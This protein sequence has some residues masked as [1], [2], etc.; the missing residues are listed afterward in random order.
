[1]QFRPAILLMA[2]VAASCSGTTA[3]TSTTATPTT[4]QTT[5]TTAA[6]TSPTT[7]TAAP[8]TTTTAA[9]PDLTP[10]VQA[11]VDWF[12]GLLNGAPFDVADYET[13]FAQLFLAQVPA[14]QFRQITEELAAAGDL[15]Q[16]VGI[17]LAVPNGAIVRVAPAGGEPAILLNLSVDGDNKVDSLLLQPAEPPTLENPPATIEEAVARLQ[18]LGTLGLAVADDTGDEACVVITEE[19]E[20]QPVSLGSMFKLYVLGAVVDAVDAGTI[21]WNQQ[22]EIVDRYRSLP[23]GIVQNDPPGSSRTVRELA[24]LMISI[25]DN[26]ATDHL[27]GLVGRRAVEQAQRAY[28][29]RIP[30]LNEPFLSTRELFILKLDGLTEPGVP[31]PV[32]REYLAADTAE[33]RA[34]LDELS[35]TSVDELNIAGW[36]KPIAVDGLEWFASPLDLC[37]V[38]ALLQA[39]P[40]AKRI[41]A[42][43]PGIPDEAG[44]WS[45][46]GFKG[47]SEPGVLGLAWYLTA[48]DGTSRVVAGTVW[49]PDEVLDETEAALLF[50]VIRDLSGPSQQ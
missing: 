45:Y 35:D 34:I 3:E 33:R 15:W 20:D 26:T 30:A 14:A 41:L 11:N 7:T 6:P 12:V 38:L 8:P 9:A 28:G 17:E 5:S 24:E 44:L 48:P 16:V 22:V 31:G 18:T 10:V 37:V 47:G 42:I 43:N 40:E 4:S 50:G 21:S 1:M 27:I 2:L 23:S 25:S 29:H 32:G 36:T 39:D 19:G 46:I 49:N 13:R